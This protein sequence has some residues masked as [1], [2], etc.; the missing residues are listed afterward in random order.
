MVLLGSL[1]FLGFFM[2]V[3]GSGFLADIFMLTLFGISREQAATMML[4]TQGSFLLMTL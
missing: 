4:L 2:R 3:P 1:V